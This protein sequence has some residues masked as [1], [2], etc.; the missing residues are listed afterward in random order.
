MT[1][2]ARC[3]S[4]QGLCFAALCIRSRHL[5]TFVAWC[6]V[7]PQDLCFPALCIRLRHLL[8]VGAWCV[9]SQLETLRGAIETCALTLRMHS[10]ASTRNPLQKLGYTMLTETLLAAALL[11]H[12][13][14][15]PAL[16]RDFETYLHNI[17]T[18]SIFTYNVC[19]Y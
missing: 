13:E 19:T 12:G 18:T 11:R 2:P 14:V 3:F 5:L 7:S 4:P 1:A 9:C 6:A 16:K 17:C 15:G 8:T 10:A